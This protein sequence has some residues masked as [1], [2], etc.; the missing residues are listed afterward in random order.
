MQVELDALDNTCTWT[1][2]DLPP[3][4]EKI[5]CKWVYKIKHHDDGT[6]E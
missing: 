4:T 2:V 1:H 3:N 5:G 6:I